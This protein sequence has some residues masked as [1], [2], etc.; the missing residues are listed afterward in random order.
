[1]TL[2]D[3]LNILSCEVATEILTDQIL[4]Y[5]DELSDANRAIPELETDLKSK[6][7]YLELMV[8]ILQKLM[9]LLLQ[10]LKKTNEVTVIQQLLLS[11]KTTWVK[12]KCI[13]WKIV[14]M[15]V[16]S[17]SITQLLK[18]MAGNTYEI[19]NL[20]LT[21][22]ES[23][24]FRDSK[25]ECPKELL[26]ML[27]HA[28]C[29]YPLMALQQKDN[30]MAAFCLKSG[31]N[32]AQQLVS[33]SSQQSPKVIQCI[34]KL[35]VVTVII[36]RMRDLEAILC[37]DPEKKQSCLANSIRNNNIAG[38]WWQLVIDLKA[39][40]TQESLTEN[41]G[42][43]FMTAYVP[44]NA[45]VSYWKASL[46][47]ASEKDEMSQIRNLIINAAVRISMFW[48]CFARKRRMKNQFFSY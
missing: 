8:N 45:A 27:D 29:L 32:S 5:F 17:C 22:I 41:K 46:E 15:G 18:T 7:L 19:Y 2:K 21:I 40:A 23:K 43:L 24:Q 48:E 35:N 47:L 42:L 36:S 1:M 12:I 13:S 30:V 25:C 28:L 3:M 6:V 11:I 16:I 26:S 33:S 31:Q 37:N 44:F 20:L 39:F 9:D 38:L 14:K 10:H 34:S 4:I